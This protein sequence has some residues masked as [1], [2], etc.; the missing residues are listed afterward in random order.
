MAKHAAVLRCQTQ[1]VSTQVFLASHAVGQSKEKK[2]FC[3]SMSSTSGLALEMISH[4]FLVRQKQGRLIPVL[5]VAGCPI[6]LC[7][8]QPARSAALHTA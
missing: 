4:R 8:L 1:E 2:L 5:A 7:Y 6:A 3:K